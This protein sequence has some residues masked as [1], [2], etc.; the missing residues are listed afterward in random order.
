ML[1]SRVLLPSAEGGYERLHHIP[2][3][4]DCGQPVLLEMPEE[5]RC[6]P[7]PITVE[8]SEFLGCQRQGFFYVS[9]LWTFVGHSDITIMIPVFFSSTLCDFSCSQLWSSQVALFLK[10]VLTKY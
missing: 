3:L 5:S 9:V 2:L 4:C 8:S 10:Q 6:W 1:S 7:V